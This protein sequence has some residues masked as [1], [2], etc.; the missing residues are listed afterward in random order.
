[1]CPPCLSTGL[2]WYDTLC[3]YGTC[4]RLDCENQ[5]IACQIIG[6]HY[7]NEPEGR[8][9]LV[10]MCR[11]E[12]KRPAVVS[13]RL[14]M[15][16]NEITDGYA[17]RNMGSFFSKTKCAGNTFSVCHSILR[18]EAKRMDLPSL[19]VLVETTYLSP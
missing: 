17:A 5:D 11:A 15:Q 4:P 2:F 18:S 9:F 19:E 13:P 12:L 16:Y 3:Y 7:G 14:F 8:M 6:R 10:Y 1:M